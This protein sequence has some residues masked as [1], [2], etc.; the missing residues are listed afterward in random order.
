M[1]PDIVSTTC[2][3]EGM[4]GAGW[5]KRDIPHNTATEHVRDDHGDGLEEQGARPTCSD[6][7]VFNNARHD[8]ERN[9]LQQ[10]EGGA[11]GRCI[12]QVMQT[13]FHIMSCEQMA[14][15]RRTQKAGAKRGRE[16]NLE[17]ALHSGHVNNGAARTGSVGA[18]GGQ[19][20]AG[21]SES[22]AMR[23]RLRLLGAALPHSRLCTLL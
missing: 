5:G 22:T 3:E 4:L 17:L 19:R 6:K 7:D 21:L 13:S 15:G 10:R 20:S 2:L 8:V 18:G 23:G 11:A 9:A 16:A 1:A 12:Y 14:A